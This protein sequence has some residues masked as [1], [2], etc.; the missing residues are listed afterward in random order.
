ILRSIIY[1]AFM[2]YIA[3]CDNLRSFFYHLKEARYWCNWMPR[4]GI[5]DITAVLIA[6]QLCSV[7]DDTGYINGFTDEN[8]QFVHKRN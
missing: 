1:E 5:D 7:K 8:T 3:S 6:F 4:E 2:D